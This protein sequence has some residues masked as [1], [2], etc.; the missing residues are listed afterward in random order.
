[1]YGQMWVEEDGRC[2]DAK[3]RHES[4]IACLKPTEDDE[5]KLRLYYDEVKRFSGADLD[6]LNQQLSSLQ[7]WFY[8]MLT[9]DQERGRQTESI[10]HD[11]QIRLQLV[12]AQAENL[13]HN[14]CRINT[15]HPPVG[16]FVATAE[17][18]LGSV[19]A[20]RVLIGNLGRSMPEYQF[21]PCLLQTLV[22]EAILMYR[23]EAE[24][25]EVDIRTRLE[26][27]STIEISRVHLQQAINNLLH[28]AIK[29]SFRGRHDRY[30]FVEVLG[31]IDGPDYVLTFSNY[32]VGILPE[33]FDLIFKPEYRGKLTHEE[34]RSGSG[35]GLVIVK[36]IIEKH[37]GA[38]K[39][40]SA[41]AGGG[42]Y[43][44][45]FI[46]RLPRKQ[47]KREEAK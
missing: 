8:G 21:R 12:L 27:P 47:P 1:M 34:Y 43:A 38:T 46:V 19:L 42:A 16:D 37:H 5:L 30:R 45:K 7:R 39:V 3:N 2:A 18:L 15:E 44:N 4:V 33:E 24:R 26:K 36:E 31:K 32:G 29:Y 40:E 20:M 13:Y 25:K 6:V 22:E 10:I 11:L 17:E 28:N 14:L 23:A 9:E 35:M 41:E